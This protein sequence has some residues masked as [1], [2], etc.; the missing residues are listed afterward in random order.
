MALIMFDRAR[1]T[2]RI[3]EADLFRRWLVAH[4]DLEPSAGEV[5]TTAAPARVPDGDKD[6]P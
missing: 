1:W 5:E 2:G 3:R 6:D 4:L